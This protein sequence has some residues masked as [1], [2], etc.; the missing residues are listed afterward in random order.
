MR[1]QWRLNQHPMKLKRITLFLM[2]MRDLV[3]CM[4]SRM[5][6]VQSTCKM[7]EKHLS[8]YIRA[9][10]GRSNK[11]VFFPLYKKT[12]EEISTTCSTVS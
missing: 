7:N 5:L 4:H 12:L 8:R 1:V 2:K 10:V 3:I 11:Y 9:E 6:D